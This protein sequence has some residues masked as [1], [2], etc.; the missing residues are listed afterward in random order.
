MLLPCL[1]LFPACGDDDGGNSL[2]SDI[3]KIETYLTDNG[4]AAEST[5][6]GLHYIIEEEGEGDNFKTGD[7]L[8]VFYT[9]KYLD[10]EVFTQIY[11]Y[12]VSFIFEG[13]IAGWNEGL[14][15]IKPGG[16]ITLFIPASLGYGSDPPQGI[17]KNAV[18]IFEITTIADL[19]AFEQTAIEDYLAD[20]ELTAEKT[21]SGLHYII[22][23]E[24]DGT[25]PD[26]GAEVTVNYQGYFLDGD[27]FDA[28]SNGS[29]TFD[30]DN[31]IEGWQEGIPL[32][33]KEGL[34]KLF[35]PSKL[36]YGKSPPNGFPQNAVLVFDIELVDF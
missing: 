31:V 32:F 11:L 9:G 13:L 6:S 14:P 3:E 22:E 24:G 19:E 28:T 5:I 23:E 1:F 35:I 25:H 26:P 34:G 12:P 8:T 29:V 18:L 7:E 30:L 2:E 4:L 27:I 15:L 20:N 33:Q 21:S 16:S 36:A 10:G 17:R